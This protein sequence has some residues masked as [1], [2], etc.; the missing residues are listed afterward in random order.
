MVEMARRQILPAVNLYIS[1]LAKTMS[2][3]AGIDPTFKTGMERD[4]VRKLSNLEDKAY[5]QVNELEK[6]LSKVTIPSTLDPEDKILEC[7]AYYK[8][9]IIPAMEKLRSLC[10]EMEADTA[11]ELW[12][13]PTYGDLL[14]S[15]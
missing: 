4:L 9:K 14:F 2:L 1:R 3:K 5:A 6:L 15:V 12:P 10:D 8:D 7:A 13:F 11:A